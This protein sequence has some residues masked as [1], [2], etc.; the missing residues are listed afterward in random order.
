VCGAAV[1]LTGCAADRADD[2]AP[3]GSPGPQEN[4]NPARDFTEPINTW[5]DSTSTP[6]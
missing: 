2:P 1:L 6:K 4:R 5:L 3:G